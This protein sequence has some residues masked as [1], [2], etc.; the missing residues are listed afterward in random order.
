MPRSKIAHSAPAGRTSKA[1]KMRAV[2]RGGN[3]A[4]GV[5]SEQEVKLGTCLGHTFYLCNNWSAGL[6]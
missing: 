1:A 3:T 6:Q 2:A 4:A 5:K